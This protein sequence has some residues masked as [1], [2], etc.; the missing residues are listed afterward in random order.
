MKLSQFGSF[1][2]VQIQVNEH[3]TEITAKGKALHRY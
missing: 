3:N 1:E 2:N